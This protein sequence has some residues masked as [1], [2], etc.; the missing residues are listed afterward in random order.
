VRNGKRLVVPDGTSGSLLLLSRALDGL[1]GA[2]LLCSTLL[3][4]SL[5]AAP[6]SLR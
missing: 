4:A 6:L 2:A 1:L 5:W 3:G